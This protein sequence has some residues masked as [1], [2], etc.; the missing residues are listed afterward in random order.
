MYRILSLITRLTIL[1][2][3]LF[4]LFIILAIR[5]WIVAHGEVSPR[6]WA[7]VMLTPSN[8]C[9]PKSNTWKTA[10]SLPTIGNPSLMYCPLSGIESARH[11]PW[12]LSRITPTPATL[13]ADWRAARRWWASR[14]GWS[15]SP[16]AFGTHLPIPPPSPTIK[17]SQYLSISEH[18]LKNYP[19]LRQTKPLEPLFAQRVATSTSSCVSARLVKKLSESPTFLGG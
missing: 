8:A 5:R 15:T 19:L 7:V 1:I 16:Y 18:S 6:W 14:I 13:S 17:L 10:A 3:S 12:P 4:F 9:T 11:T 2:L